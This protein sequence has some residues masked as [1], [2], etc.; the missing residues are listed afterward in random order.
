MNEEAATAKVYEALLQS[1]SSLHLE[2]FNLTQSFEM[3][4][5]HPL[6]A[7]RLVC[8]TVVDGGGAGRGDRG[9]EVG[10]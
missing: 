3:E 9:Y 5:R 2:S 8:K 10:G 6:F 1:W 7:F 4:E